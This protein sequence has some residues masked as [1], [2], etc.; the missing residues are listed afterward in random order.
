MLIENGREPSLLEWGFE[1]SVSEG[2]IEEKWILE[3]EYVN[4]VVYH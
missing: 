3:S 1:V 2:R 4:S